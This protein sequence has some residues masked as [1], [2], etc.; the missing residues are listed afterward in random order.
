M[1]TVLSNPFM[2]PG[3]GL[4]FNI[5]CG[6]E[7]TFGLSPAL[8]STFTREGIVGFPSSLC[9]QYLEQAHG[10]KYVVDEKRMSKWEIRSSRYAVRLLKVFVSA[11]HQVS[12]YRQYSE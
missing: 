3:P 11:R 6:Q 10:N 1:S 2:I 12:E 5:C 4:V 9:F 8:T 7:F